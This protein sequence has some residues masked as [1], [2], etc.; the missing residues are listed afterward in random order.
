M[1][2]AIK[3]FA[4]LS[5]PFFLPD[6]QPVAVVIHKKLGRLSSMYFSNS[7]FI[8][9]WSSKFINR[10]AFLCSCCEFSSCCGVSMTVS[11]SIKSPGSN[12]NDSALVQYIKNNS[13]PQVQHYTHVQW[14]FWNETEKSYAAR[15]ARRIWFFSFG[16]EPP[17][18]VCVRKVF[19]LYFSS[20]LSMSNLKLHQT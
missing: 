14:G 11:K 16:P 4:A 17:L 20:F 6:F 15:Q 18:Y 10:G 9:F 7:R 1:G 5:A 13:R 8:N 2:A 19:C 12:Y 3:L